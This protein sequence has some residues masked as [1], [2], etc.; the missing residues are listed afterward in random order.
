MFIS[1]Q[2]FCH[3]IYSLILHAHG[4]SVKKQGVQLSLNK[5]IV[6]NCCAPISLF[7]RCSVFAYSDFPRMTCG[8]AHTRPLPAM[9]PEAM[10]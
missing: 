8:L 1:L 10:L 2:Q 7:Q 3:C 6:E 9:F 5:L 4:T